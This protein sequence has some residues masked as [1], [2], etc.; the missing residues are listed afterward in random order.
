MSSR[1]IRQASVL[2]RSSLA[3]AL[4]LSLGGTGA[5]LAQST[6][7]N[8]FGSATPTDAM[9]DPGSDPDAFYKL[10]WYQHTEGHV[11][12]PGFDEFYEHEAR[13]AAPRTGL[14]PFKDPVKRNRPRRGMALLD[15]GATPSA[16]G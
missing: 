3:L 11:P 13:F 16:A 6:S 9:P 4:A 8:I 1:S 5:V 7:G 15:L 12:W 10:G 14:L 2:R